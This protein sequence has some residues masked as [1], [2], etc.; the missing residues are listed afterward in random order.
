MSS[1]LASNEHHIAYPKD[2]STKANLGLKTFLNG[3]QTS[4]STHQ[5]SP[6]GISTA[7]MRN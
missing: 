3:T 2:A 1:R 7:S 6:L 5:M 4:T